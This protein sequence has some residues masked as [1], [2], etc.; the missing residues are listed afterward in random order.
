MDYVTRQFI[1]LTKQF[2]KELRT[3]IESLRK[4][5][6]QQTEAIRKARD[7]YEQTCQTPPILRAELQVPQPVEVQ[8][9]PKDKK[10]A[11]EWYRLAVETLTLLAVIG[12]AAITIRM[13]REMIFTRHQAQHAVD[14]AQQSAGAAL[15]ANIAASNRFAIDQRP[16]VWVPDVEPLPVV[17]LQRLRAD[18]FFVNYG[19]SP[20]MNE[21]G[22]GKI[23]FGKNAVKQAYQWFDS[24]GTPEQ[25]AAFLAKNQEGSQAV[26]APGIPTDIAKQGGH[27]TILSDAAPTQVEVNWIGANDYSA[28]V[29]LRFQYYDLSGNRYWTDVCV[30][31]FASTAIGHCKKHNEIH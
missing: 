29:A 4:D 30:F 1:N 5:I 19:K 15:Q 21:S 24:L 16:Y 27:S 14:A 13:W 9:S 23:F 8:T 10:Q 22:V 3:L 31:H 2:R 20:A 17:A 18:V 25:L 7:A 12:Y 6:Q 11:R 28:V 26:V